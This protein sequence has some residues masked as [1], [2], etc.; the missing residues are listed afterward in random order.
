[1]EVQATPVSEIV[2][3]AAV[4]LG[5]VAQ[6]AINRL[7]IGPS[8][9]VADAI[10]QGFARVAPVFLV[11]AVVMFVVALVAVAVAMLLSAAGVGILPAAGKTPPAS[12][13]SLLVLL[14]AAATAIF[15]LV[16]PL[17]AAE[18][19]NP[20]RLFTRSWQLSRGHYLRLFG[21]I[22]TVFAAL[23]IV[24]LLTQLGVGSV[25]LL[26]IGRPTPG[27]LSAL[28]IGLVA[29]V[30]QAAFAVIVA[31]MQARIY[32]QLVGNGEPLR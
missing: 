21:F 31:V 24:T 3:I 18:T 2:Y 13:L 15:Q 11:L 22:I 20:I 6:I 5:F 14:T 12:L 8:V 27:S 19:G 30:V 7:A 17:A 10:A 16:F 1:M 26:L 25:I 28:A 32:I 23:G 9:R 4:L 29:G